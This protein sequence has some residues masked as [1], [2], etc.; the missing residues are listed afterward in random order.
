MN[1][2]PGMSQPPPGMVP[3]PQQYPY[4]MPPA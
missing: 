1:N 2:Y 4:G 3:M